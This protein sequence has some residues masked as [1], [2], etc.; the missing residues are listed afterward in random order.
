MVG[1]NEVQAEAARLHGDEEHLDGRLLHELLHRSLTVLL[2]HRSVEADEP[3][4]RAS[5]GGLDKVQH[6]SPLRENN[7]LRVRFCLAEVN[8]LLHESVQLRAACPAAA[9]LHGHVGVRDSHVMSTIDMSVMSASLVGPPLCGVVSRRR[10]RRLLG[11]GLE[12]LWL[13]VCAARGASDVAGALH[14]V[15]LVGD[16]SLD[17]LSTEVVSASRDQRHLHGLHAEHALCLSRCDLLLLLL[18]LFLLV[19]QSLCLSLCLRLCL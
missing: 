3:D 11:E 7:G 15:E 10:R 9:L 18:L 5:E 2:Y 12:Q 13:E 1:G 16:V 4:A 17:A 19:V 8:Q 6:R 14:G